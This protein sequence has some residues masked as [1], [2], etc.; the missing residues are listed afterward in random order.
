M[1]TDDYGNEIKPGDILRLCVGIPGRDVRVTVKARRGRLIVENDEGS[2]A[3]SS[4]L[5]VFPVEVLK[6]QER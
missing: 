2:M 4:A 6:S 1:P 5:R 3:L